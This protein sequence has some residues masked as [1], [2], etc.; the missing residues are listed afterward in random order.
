VDECYGEFWR[1]NSQ[2]ARNFSARLNSFLYF[3]FFTTKSGAHGSVVVNKLCYKKAKS[4]QLYETRD[5]LTEQIEVI[6]QYMHLSQRMSNI[7]LL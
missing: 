6:G 4:E 1:I 7:C 5:V 3:S 2:N